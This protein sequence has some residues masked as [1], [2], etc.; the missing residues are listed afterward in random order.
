MS[1]SHGLNAAYRYQGMI[2]P[3]LAGDNPGK[4]GSQMGF[5]RAEPSPQDEVKT[6]NTGSLDH[7]FFTNTTHLA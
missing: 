7:I 4:E 1:H 5:S 6:L 2:S 3:T